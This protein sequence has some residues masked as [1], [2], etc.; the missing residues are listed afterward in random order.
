[1]FVAMMIVM[2]RRYFCRRVTT[3]GPSM[4][5][6]FVIHY[7]TFMAMNCIS[8]LFH[9]CLLSISRA[10]SLAPIDF[11]VSRSRHLLQLGWP[12]V[13]GAAGCVS[14]HNKVCCLAI[15]LHHSSACVCPQ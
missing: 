4:M 1:M 9:R 14:L 10:L 15:H 11:D 3:L 6:F 7:L 12:G 13:G 5:M 2:R 8:R